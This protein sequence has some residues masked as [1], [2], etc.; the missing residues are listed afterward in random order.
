LRQEKKI[1]KSRKPEEKLK[2]KAVMVRLTS[3]DFDLFERLADELQ[4]S[5]AAVI[6]LYALRALKDKK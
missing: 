1:K 5:I 2:V 6:R 3:S 4:T